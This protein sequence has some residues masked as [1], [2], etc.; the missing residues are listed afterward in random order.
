MKTLLTTFCLTI[1]VLL[2]SVGVSGSADFKPLQEVLKSGTPQIALY[3][4]IRCSALFYASSFKHK[5]DYDKEESTKK[6]INEGEK[7]AKN[8]NLLANLFVKK[9]KLSMTPK[10][11]SENIEKIMGEYD[12]IW[13]NN[14]SR[15]GNDF[16]QLTLQD[17]KVC[18]ELGK[19]LL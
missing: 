16:G 9:S 4:L 19:T 5:L 12:I 17:L 13:K 18:S 2:G 15:T 3:G 6:V 10:Q 7:V 14:Y 8:F 11:I 1:A